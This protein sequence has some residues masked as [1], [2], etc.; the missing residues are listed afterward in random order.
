MTIF[1]AHCY[2]SFQFLLNW[3]PT[4]DP[5]PRVFPRVPCLGGDHEGEEKQSEQWDTPW[6]CWNAPVWIFLGHGF[7]FFLGNAWQ[8]MGG[9]Y[10]RCRFNF[11]GNC[12]TS[13]KWL[14]PFTLASALCVR[15]PV[16]QDLYAKNDNAV[17]V[18]ACQVLQ[19]SSV[20]LL[21]R[22]RLFATPWIAACQAS[23]SITNSWSLLK[24]MSIGDAIQ[25][26][27]PLSSPSP[28]VPNPSQ[29]QGLF[30]WVNSLNWSASVVSNSLRPHGL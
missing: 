20:Q 29:H 18:H 10:A 14:W 26:S 3:D 4:A 1:L 24:L 5:K 27:H 7:P 28:P 15:G 11:L 25:P 22:V 17:C 13:P 12:Q 19:F 30:Q 8:R 16:F 9:S 6:R 21:S 2:F 23:L